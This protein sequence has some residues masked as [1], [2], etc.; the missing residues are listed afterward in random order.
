M[1]VLIKS[2]PDTTEAR[3]GMKFARD[4]SAR[5]V[6]LQNGVYHVRKGGLE[7]FSGEVFVLDT[8]LKLRGALAVADNIKSISY[9]EFVGLMMEDQKVLGM[10]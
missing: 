4:L 3:R 7:G 1:L 2:A 10:F 6:L 9:D 5:L 8:D